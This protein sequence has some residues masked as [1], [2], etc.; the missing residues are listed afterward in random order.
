M[1]AERSMSVEFLWNVFD[2]R[3]PM[4]WEINKFTPLPLRLPQR[5]VGLD[6]DRIGA[7]ALRGRRLTS[8]GRHDIVSKAARGDTKGWSKVV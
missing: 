5:K 3:K 6:W 1:V 2:R 4:Y 8:R 7:S